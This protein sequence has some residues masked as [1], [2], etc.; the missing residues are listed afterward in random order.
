MPD[1]RQCPDCLTWGSNDDH[2]C[3]KYDGPPC[4]TCGAGT[5]SGF[6]GAP[7]SGRFTVCANGH[8]LGDPPHILTAA[9]VI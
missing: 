6:Y 3:V 9:D 5:V 8:D 4:P 7:A 2:I 1:L